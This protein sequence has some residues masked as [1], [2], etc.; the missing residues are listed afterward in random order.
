LSP[1]KSQAQRAKFAE[2]VKQGKMEQS[3]FDEWQ[4]ATGE[5]KLPERIAKPAAKG[6]VRKVKTIRVIK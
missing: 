2:L 1:F 6:K 5:A 4:K 3:T